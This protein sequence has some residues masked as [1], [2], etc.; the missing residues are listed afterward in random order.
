MVEKS[1]KWNFIKQ[2]LKNGG[3]VMTG[4]KAITSLVNSCRR[5]VGQ[6]FSITDDTD[7]GISADVTEDRTRLTISAKFVTLQRGTESGRRGL[8]AFNGVINDRDQGTKKEKLQVNE[9]TNMKARNLFLFIL[10]FL[11]QYICPKC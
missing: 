2:N 5:A 7:C 11:S 9:W 6:V 3:M 4:V 1:R 10:V 8:T